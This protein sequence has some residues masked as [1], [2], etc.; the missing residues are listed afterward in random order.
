M[1][2]DS[3]SK[4]K[5]RKNER[6]QDYEKILREI[7]PTL[8]S[9]ERK[10]LENAQCSD[11]SSWLTTLPLREENFILNKQEFFD[12]IFMRYGMADEET[13]GVT[14]SKYSQEKSTP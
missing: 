12:A 14:E 3:I 1:Y 6:L 5:T 8:S 4:I 7:E 9:I 10:A 2:K 11:A 13:T